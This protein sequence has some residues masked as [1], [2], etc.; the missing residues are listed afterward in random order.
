VLYARLEPLLIANQP[1]FDQLPYYPLYI[2]EKHDFFDY[3]WQLTIALIEELHQQVKTDGAAFGVVFISP[4]DV[5]N[6]SR[7]STEAR[8]TLYYEK[9]PDL[10]KAQ[11]DRPNTRLATRLSQDGINFLDL[12]P[13]FIQHINETGEGL[14]YSVDKHWNIAGN[15]VAAEAIYHWLDEK[16]NP[17]LVSN[18]QDVSE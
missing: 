5:I 10:Q 15:R 11:L 16:T 17:S 12:Q 13:V 1:R 9:V 2:P 4:I 14:Y 8:K 6:I 7:L 18:E 3:G